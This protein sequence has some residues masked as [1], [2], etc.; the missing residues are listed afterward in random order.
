MRFSLFLSVVIFIQ[1]LYGFNFHSGCKSGNL[2]LL[3][4]TI[5]SDRELSTLW[6]SIQDL[7]FVAKSRTSDSEKIIWNQEAWL[8]RL[9][10]DCGYGGRFCLREHLKSRIVELRQRIDRPK[11]IT[12]ATQRMHHSAYSPTSENHFPYQVKT[13]YPI[14]VKKDALSQSPLPRFELI[15]R[16]KNMEYTIEGKRYRLYNGRYHNS[17]EYAYVDFGRLLTS[18]DM[19]GDG[20]TDYVVT[21]YFNGGGSGIFPYLFVVFQDKGTFFSSLPASLPDRSKIDSATIRDSKIVLSLIEPGPN[22]PGCCPSLHRTRIYR[23]IGQEL[24]LIY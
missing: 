9:R 1:S 4:Q 14:R 10:E 11:R 2:G 24:S 17:A 15:R 13:H 12:P 18:G 7:L 23:V 6:S 19:D 3:S 20:D 21:V 22:D 16:L 8:R 5:C